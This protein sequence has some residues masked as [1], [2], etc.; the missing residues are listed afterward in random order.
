MPL[1]MSISG[2]PRNGTCQMIVPEL[3]FTRAY[4]SSF[5]RQSVAHCRVAEQFVQ[6]DRHRP[7]H[8]G[9]VLAALSDA[10]IKVHIR[11]D[12]PNLLPIAL[13]QP[14]VLSS[15]AGRDTQSPG[16]APA[17]AARRAELRGKSP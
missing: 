15:R 2:R 1:A 9:L 13:L 12:R 14:E 11:L 7:L 4:T 16:C 8:V 6:N 10:S 17:G 5:T 3:D